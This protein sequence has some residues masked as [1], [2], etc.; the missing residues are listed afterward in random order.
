MMQDN[1]QYQDTSG[2][3]KLVLAGLLLLAVLAA[4]YYLVEVAQVGQADHAVIKHGADALA[5]RQCLDRY[6][7]NEVWQ[8]TSWRR[9]NHFIR[10]CQLD[11][12]R[13]G[14]QIIQ[15]TRLNGLIEKTSFVVK[16]GSLFELRQY[17]TARAVQFFDSLIVF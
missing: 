5:I 15:K 4:G 14:L 10:T 2:L 3:S 16:D 6:G 9:P 8:M 13:W 12:G 1:M 17:V 7:P 11:D